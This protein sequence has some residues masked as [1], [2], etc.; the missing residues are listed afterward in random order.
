[1]LRACFWHQTLF[2]SFTKT[3][4]GSNLLT[5]SRFS[6]VNCNPRLF[7]FQANTLILSICSYFNLEKKQSE[8]HKLILK[9]EENT[10]GFLKNRRKKKEFN[11]DRTALVPNIKLFWHWIIKKHDFS[12]FHEKKCFTN[13]FDNFDD[14]WTWN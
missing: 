2:V 9:I 6:T 13:S 4:P 10:W 12:F 8:C 11:N 1:M 7:H 5:M 14:F 3:S